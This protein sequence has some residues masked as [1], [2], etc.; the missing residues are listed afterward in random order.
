VP[1]SSGRMPASASAPPKPSDHAQ[2]LLNL[3]VIDEIIPSR[4]R[5]PCDPRRRRRRSATR[6][7][8]ISVS[9]A[10]SKTDKLLKTA[11]R[12]V[13]FHGCANEK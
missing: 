3:G 5:R 7:S 2:D 9:S 11:R 1:L 4:R 12:K 10:S 13:P 8:G 6:C